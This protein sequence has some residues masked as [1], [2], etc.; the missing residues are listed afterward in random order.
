MLPELAAGYGLAL[1]ATAVRKYRVEEL[2]IVPRKVIVGEGT[3]AMPLRE[4]RSQYF[5]R[6]EGGASFD[7]RKCSSIRGHMGASGTT[8][9]ARLPLIAEV[10]RAD[11]KGLANLLKDIGDELKDGDVFYLAISRHADLQGNFLQRML[12]LGTPALEVFYDT[13]ERTRD[14]RTRYRD[15][16][17][18]SIPEFREMFKPVQESGSINVLYFETCFGGDF[19]KALVGGTT[20]TLSSS[21]PGKEL[22]AT[23]HLGAWQDPSEPS[24][25]H[26][27]HTRSTFEEGLCRNKT[28]L[29]AFQ[30]AG[31][32]QGIGYGLTMIKPFINRPHLFVGDIDPSSIRLR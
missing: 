4:D 18:I 13:I 22:R 20:T 7:L 28:V 3:E 19:A 24:L 15:P 6:Q 17:P 21:G 14:S 8:S 9:L 26:V 11:R 16:S 23:R 12:N 29:Q 27:T 30:E 32:E 25:G 2:G 10:D 1:L 31:H 5:L